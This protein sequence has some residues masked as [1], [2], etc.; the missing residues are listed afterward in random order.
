MRPLTRGTVH[1][2][3]SNISQSPD[4]DPRYVTNSYDLRSLVEAGKFARKIAQTEPLASFLA[5]EYAPGIPAVSTD[6]QWENYIRQT[7]RTI[8]HY[9]GTC[10]MLPKHDGGVVDS[11]LRVWGTSNLRVADASI[12]CTFLA[13][14]SLETSDICGRTKNTSS[15]IAYLLLQIPVL[16]ASH[17]QTVTYGI[18]E[19]AA[20][21]IIEDHEGD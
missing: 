20:D 17:T 15:T 4:I 1:I 16:V 5:G 12:V 2:R 21:I 11:R 13:S 10:A 3:S 9:S 18:A 19:R 7:M 8:Y 14:L 6:E